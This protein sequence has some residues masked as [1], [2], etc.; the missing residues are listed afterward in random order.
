MPD[1][2]RPVLR[3][4]L[5]PRYLALLAAVLALAAAFVGLSQWQW[6]RSR[7]G[8]RDEAQIAAKNHVRPLAEVV[9]PQTR[10]PGDAMDQMV[11]ATG[12][13]RSGGQVLVPGRVQPGS[14]E[15]GFWVV[16]PLRVDATAADLPVVRGWVADAARVPAAPE[17]RVTVTGRVQPGESPRTDPGLGAHR[18]GSVSPAQLVNLWDAPI[19]TGYVIA[20]AGA[21]PAAGPV[22]PVP[23]EAQAGGGFNLLNLAYAVEWIV[24]AGFALYIWWR[25]VADRYRREEEAREAR[26]ADEASDVS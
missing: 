4:A 9:R 24:F 13:F 23:T 25:T 6:D 8:H 26:A 16:T 17:G 15:R 14:T 10:L 12:T 1:G 3:V 21:A 18:V 2:A 5:R 7:A 20:T 22:R 19:Y 11:R